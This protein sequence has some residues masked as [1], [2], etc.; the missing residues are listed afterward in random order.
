[1]HRVL[2]LSRWLGG[3]RRFFKLMHEHELHHGFRF[4]DGLQV[5]SKP[6]NARPG[7]GG[8]HFCEEQDVLWWAE[9]VFGG[10]PGW[11]RSVSVPPFAR[12][13]HDAELRFWKAD[14]IRLGPRVPW[15]LWIAARPELWV[16]R[17]AQLAPIQGVPDAEVT[18][19]VCR[20]AAITEGGGLGCIPH[21]LRSRDLCLDVVKHRGWQ[22][23]LV[24]M[25]LRTPALCEAAVKQNGLALEEVPWDL[26]SPAMCEAAVRQNG[27]ALADVPCDLQ[28]ASLCAAAVAQNGLALDYTP[29]ALKSP[30]L[31]TAAVKQNGLALEAVPVALRTPELCAEAVKQSSRALV[32]VPMALRT[33]ALCASALASSSLEKARAVSRVFSNVRTTSM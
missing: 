30:A 12:M 22:L 9:H 18:S 23:A 5:D 25:N 19:D 33:P 15:T 13:S 27:L 26:R 21:P 11:V 29:L 16:K 24:P 3:R 31:C 14:R 2:P 4:S 32:S 28:T 20:F 7:E 8:F 10:R 17:I 1:M 6:W